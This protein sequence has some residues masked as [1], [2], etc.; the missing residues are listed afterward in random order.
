MVQPRLVNYSH[1]PSSFSFFLPKVTTFSRVHAAGSLSK[2]DDL[3]YR[4]PWCKWTCWDFECWQL[5]DNVISLITNLNNKMATNPAN[6]RQ[7]YSPQRGIKEYYLHTVT[8]MNFYELFRAVTILV[9]LYHLRH[10]SSKNLLFLWKKFE[11]LLVLDQ[12]RRH[13]YGN[14]CFLKMNE[15]KH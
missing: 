8:V 10:F 14:L 12:I 4:R 5:L 6:L 11:Y 7:L 1:H 2:R 13:L 3:S 15:N 9:H